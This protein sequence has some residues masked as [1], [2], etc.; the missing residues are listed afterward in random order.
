MV[1]Y[2]IPLTLIISIIAH[3][4]HSQIM[5]FIKRS[6][7]V[8]TK[9]PVIHIEIAV[10]II[11]VANNK[12]IPNNYNNF[13]CNNNSS[14]CSGCNSNLPNPNFVKYL[15]I[16]VKKK[17]YQAPAHNKTHNPPWIPKLHKKQMG[18]LIIIWPLQITF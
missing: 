4:I 3:K 8:K 11:I 12:W 17:W 10:L 1:V 18:I 5:S 2:L 6:I 13:N 16:I 7:I 15:M 14:K 9:V